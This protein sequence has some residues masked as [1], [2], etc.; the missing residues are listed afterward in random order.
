[1]N[2]LVRIGS[3]A[4]QPHKILNESVVY[5]MAETKKIATRQAFGDELAKIG[6]REDIVVMDAD[7]TKSTMTNV[8]AAKYPERHINCGIAEGNM[9]AT[10]AGLASCGKTVFAASFAM[11]SAGRAYEQVRNS[12]GYP[13]LNVKVVG[14]H[15][16][17][18]VGEDGASHQCIEDTALMR[19]IPGMVVISP[20]DGVETAAAIRAVA[21]YKGPVYLR[22]SRLAMPVLFDEETYK[23]EIGKGSVM[24]DGTDV[25]IIGT[26]LLL[27]EAIKA[28][29]MLK[30]EGISVRLVNIP[31]IK[32][33]DTALVLE[34]AKKTGAVVC[35]EEHSVIGG[36]GSAVCDALACGMS[37]ADG[38]VPVEIVGLEDTFGRSGKPEA[39]LEYYK[40]SAPYIVEKAKKAIGRK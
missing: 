29:D 31:T 38:F 34:S 13:Q 5:I 16:G 28:V 21:D 12:I 3:R 30:A 4:L 36:L 23:F 11:F 15:A 22:L 14:T 9:M 19:A 27:H 6:A 20:A 18:T 26:G 24:Q 17:V 33:L 40:L 35:V 7:L 8:F 1:L 2:L 37:A 32:P 25:T 39:L 10:A